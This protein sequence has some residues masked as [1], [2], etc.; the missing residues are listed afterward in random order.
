M[1]N[2]R[3]GKI[4]YILRHWQWQSA[5]RVQRCNAHARSL[6]HVWS[7]GASVSPTNVPTQASNLPVDC[8]ER[9]TVNSNVQ[10]KHVLKDNTVPSLP[11]QIDL[12]ASHCVHAIRHDSDIASDLR[13]FKLILTL[14]H[15]MCDAKA[16]ALVTAYAGAQVPWRKPRGWGGSRAA[17]RNLSL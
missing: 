11:G 10:T 13:R 17:P 14:S 9:L 1:Q 15:A 2:K 5:V 4:A 3:S 6:G 12:M 7:A 16:D 8:G